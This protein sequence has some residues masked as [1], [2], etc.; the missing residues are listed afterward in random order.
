MRIKTQTQEAI[1]YKL[2]LI[3][4]SREEKKRGLKFGIFGVG[5]REGFL[6]LREFVLMWGKR[7][8]QGQRGDVAA[9]KKFPK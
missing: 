5:R 9:S 4:N 8:G 1:L 2:E 7:L 3:N 6:W